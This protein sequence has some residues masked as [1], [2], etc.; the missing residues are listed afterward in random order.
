MINAS[1]FRS[2]FINTSPIAIKIWW[3]FRFI[4]TSILIQLSLQNVVQDTAAV[5]SWHVQKYVVIWW[6]ATELQQGKF[7]IKFE[8]TFGDL[9]M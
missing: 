9:V 4:V 6:P 5:L 3:K 7:S 8:F 2:R 1:T